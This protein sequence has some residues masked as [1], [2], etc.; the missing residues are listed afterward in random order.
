MGA[1]WLARSSS[2]RRI[3]AASGT[4]PTEQTKEAT[5]MRGP[6]SGPTILASAGSWVKNT[7]DQTPPGIHAAKAPAINRPPTRSTHREA[8]SITK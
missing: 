5:A 8:Q 4:L 7:D 3:W 1:E 6:S 2:T